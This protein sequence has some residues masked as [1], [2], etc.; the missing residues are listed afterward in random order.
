M[1]RVYFMRFGLPLGLIIL[2]F[3]MLALAHLTYAHLFANMV[4]SG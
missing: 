3:V 2:A 1:K 4:W